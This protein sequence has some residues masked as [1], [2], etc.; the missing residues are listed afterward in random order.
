[1][2][3]MITAKIAGK[4]RQL[5][6]SIEVMFNM[7]D[8]FGSIQDALD[9]IAKD[10]A[11]AFDAVKWFALQMANDAE[12]CRRDAGYDPQPMISEKD[13]TIRMRPLD[14]EEL[15]AAVVDAITLGY[16]REIK[17]DKEE[18]DIGLAELQAKKAEA[19]A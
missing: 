7:R 2:D 8:K 17:D 15:K 1:M 10:G 11:E 4:D 18:T 14:Y 16:R 12:L 19:R 6:Y 9:I 13:I 3:R 5:N